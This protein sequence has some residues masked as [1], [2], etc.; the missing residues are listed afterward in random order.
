MRACPPNTAVHIS[1]NNHLAPVFR[2][3]GSMT[4]LSISFFRDTLFLLT[5]ILK[6]GK[7]QKEVKE[8]KENN[9]ERQW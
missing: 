9:N 6:K 3:A 8:R 2:V 4:L 7:T 5:A 1:A